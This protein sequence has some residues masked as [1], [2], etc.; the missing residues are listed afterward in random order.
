[1]KT[2]MKKLAVCVAVALSSTFTMSVA[3]ATSFQL[4]AIDLEGFVNPIGAVVVDNG[5]GTSTF[6]NLAYSFDV[7]ATI[8]SQV[9]AIQI[10]FESDI[11]DLSG[12]SLT[13]TDP[14]NWGTSSSTVGDFLYLGFAAGTKLDAGERFAFTLDDVIIQNAALTDPS[15]WN[16]GQ[17]WAQPWVALGTHHAFDGGSTSP[18]PEPGTVVLLGSGLLGMVA[19]GRRRMQANA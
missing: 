10:G 13:A 9:K 4:G 5:D 19:W 17:V 6:D 2:S 16:E 14:N 11:F 18:V 3:G 8:N 1:M 7:V 12:Y 15:F